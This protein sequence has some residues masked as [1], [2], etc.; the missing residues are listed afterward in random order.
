MEQLYPLPDG[1]SMFDR[2]PKLKKQFESDV[3]KGIIKLPDPNLPQ[4][5]DDDQDEKIDRCVKEVWGYYD[6][7]NQG[8]I[9]KK[10][11]EQFFKDALEL[12]SIRKGC[13]SPKEL[14]PPG[15]SMGKALDSAFHSLDKSGQGRI[16]FAAFA[17]FVNQSDLD[18][19]LSLIT[20]QT[21]A[22]E[23]EAVVSQAKLVDVAAIAA[24]NPK[25]VVPGQIQYRNYD[26]D[27]N[28]A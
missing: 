1:A 10:M 21:G 28:D 12:F 2:D 5:V 4:D 18:E 16:D 8:F 23:V 3:K 20:G 22:R 14:L 6:K 11:G 27:V 19:A 9:D 17:E 26:Q 13:K 7:K 25:K 15:G 24:S